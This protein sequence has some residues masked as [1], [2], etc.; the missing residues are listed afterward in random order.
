MGGYIMTGRAVKP[1]DPWVYAPNTLI[2]G[3]FERQIRL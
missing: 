2:S 3:D 1:H